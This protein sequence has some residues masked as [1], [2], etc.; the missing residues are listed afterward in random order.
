MLPIHQIEE[1]GDLRVTQLQCRAHV[2]LDS[3]D[4]ITLPQRIEVLW[5]EERKEGL[6]FGKVVLIIIDLDDLDAHPAAHTVHLVGQM[7]DQVVGLALDLFD[8]L[9][10]LHFDPAYQF[11]L[12]QRQRA[13]LQHGQLGLVVQSQHTI[14]GVDGLRAPKVELVTLGL[15]DGIHEHEIQFIEVVV[16]VVVMTQ[17]QQL[18]DVEVV[19]I[20]VVELF[21][22]RRVVIIVGE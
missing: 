7:E 4:A 3:T 1:E 12:P 20:L 14:R 15:G 18:S 6:K 11:V 21:G 10:G 13:Q 17:Q 19:S 8:D 16:V 5:F 2:L 9:L 22:S